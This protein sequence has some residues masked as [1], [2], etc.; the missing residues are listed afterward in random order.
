MHLAQWQWDE[1]CSFL[2][3]R[4]LCRWAAVNRGSRGAIAAYTRAE[5][6]E[7]PIEKGPLHS[8]NEL[9]ERRLLAHIYQKTN[10]RGWQR[11][12][13]W[14]GPGP[15][16][17]WEG[18]GTS[19]L[20]SVVSLSLERIGDLH[21]H[22]P[23]AIANLER[24]QRLVLFSTKLSGAMPPSLGRLSDLRVVRLN[25]TQLTGHI[26]AAICSLHALRELRLNDTYV[27]GPIPHDVG[28][29]TNLEILDLSASEYHQR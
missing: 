4:H 10:G 26:P 7:A 13:G 29:L 3:A 1:C 9:H 12:K 5:L 20:G 21:G 18:I 14:L 2:S 27:H 8:L 24:L 28:A 6:G 11:Q 16:G 15:V 25:N 17:G 19:P 23:E 22:L